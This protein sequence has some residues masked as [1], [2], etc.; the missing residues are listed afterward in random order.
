MN[1]LSLALLSIGLASG[2]FVNEVVKREIWI[3]SLV[4]RTDITIHYKG[5]KEAEYVFGL[6]EERVKDLAYISFFEPTIVKDIP[7]RKLPKC[8]NNVKGR[9]CWQVNLPNPAEGKLAIKMANINALEAFP[10]KVKLEDPFRLKFQF[11]PHFWSP[12]ETKKQK[13]FVE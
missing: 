8:P 7:S 11:N 10:K 9:I 12:Y 1:C 2:S 13:T 4:V 3:N 6:E 5:S